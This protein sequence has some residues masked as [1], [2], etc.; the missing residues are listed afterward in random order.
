MKFKKT[1]IALVAIM[2]LLYPVYVYSYWSLQR[3]YTAQAVSATFTV[4]TRKF[5]SKSA[6]G[7]VEVLKASSF[8]SR[9]KKRDAYVTQLNGFIKENLPSSYVEVNKY[10]ARE[11]S[12]ENKKK[13]NRDYQSDYNFLISR[14]IEEIV[15]NDQSQDNSELI[16]GLSL[17]QKIKYEN[18]YRGLRWLS[19]LVQ[20]KVELTF[21]D[22][23]P[24]T[25]GRY[26]M[27]SNPL[28]TVR[29]EMR[30]N[31]IWT[32]DRTLSNA[33]DQKKCQLNRLDIHRVLYSLLR[34]VFVEKWFGYIRIPVGVAGRFFSEQFMF[35]EF[36]AIDDNLYELSKKTLK[37]NNIVDSVEN[38]QSLSAYIASSDYRN[39][40][41]Y[42]WALY[43]RNVLGDKSYSIKK[44]FKFVP[45][46]YTSSEIETELAGKCDK[47]KK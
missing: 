5:R 14:Q 25:L 6:E 9:E 41:Q 15:S 24:L 3:W 27:D 36:D 16:R 40:A 11:E 44:Q 38:I 42:W 22:T 1:I 12:G 43:K 31:F 26:S 8:L 10:F 18:L 39:G 33:A 37:L 46:V 47:L 29:S 13:L 2:I 19:N 23:F 28:V 32:L 34:P 45:T 30:S 21:L 20:Y 35:M 4:F 17:E 7:Y